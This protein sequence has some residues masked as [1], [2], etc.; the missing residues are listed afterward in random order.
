MAEGFDQKRPPWPPF[1]SVSVEVQS[2]F[3]SGEELACSGL[4]QG[5][6]GRVVEWS[7][8]TKRE[9]RGRAGFVVPGRCS[10]S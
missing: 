3:R 5:V 10:V 1:F 2:S 8:K 7:G 9:K 4:S 6:S